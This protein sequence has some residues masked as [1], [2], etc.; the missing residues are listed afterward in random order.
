MLK[1]YSGNAA[2]LSLLSSMLFAMQFPLIKVSL[3]HISAPIAAIFECIFTGLLC[4]LAAQVVGQKVRLIFNSKLIAA[5]LLNATGLIFLFEGLARVHPGIIGLIGRLYFVYAMLISYVHFQERPQRGEM[6]MITF[7][8]LG[9]FLVSFQTGSSTIG[10]A[11]GVILAFLYPAFFAVQ[12]AVIKPIVKQFD[13]TAILFNT[14]VYA[15][16]PLVIYFLVRHGA[17]ESVVSLT[18]VAIIFCSTFLSTFLGLLLF[19]KA[20]GIATFRFANLM[21]ATE[22]V[23]VLVFSCFL[24][25]VELTPQNIIGTLLILTSVGVVAYLQSSP[26]ASLQKSNG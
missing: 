16:S 23:F 12:N 7:A 5:G 21:K 20:L 15:L 18:G 1:R 4:L 8:I 11:T 24:F 26:M 6:F 10:S 22:P 13:T 17:T 14:K 2:A 9:V 19:Y 3:G 25:P